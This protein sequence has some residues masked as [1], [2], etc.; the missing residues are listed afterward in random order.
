[1][2]NL[3]NKRVSKKKINKIVSNFERIFDRNLG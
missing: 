3:F 2:P 1:M